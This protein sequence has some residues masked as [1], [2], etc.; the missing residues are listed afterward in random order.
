MVH[1]SITDRIPSS[2]A[3]ATFDTGQLV[4]T[5]TSGNVYRLGYNSATTSQNY[6]WSS[7]LAGKTVDTFIIQNST[8]FNFTGS[9]LINITN[10]IVTSS[11]TV[12]FDST[13]SF[14]ITNLKIKDSASVT[15]SNAV[16]TTF[17]N[18]EITSGTLRINS[19][20]ANQPAF[21]A[22]GGTTYVNTDQVSF[23]SMLVG[24]TGPATVT[25]N[26]FTG[27]WSSSS[28]S[29]SPAAGNGQLILNV[30]G[31][32]TVGSL[33]TIHM[34]GRGYAGGV[35][36]QNGYSYNGQGAGGAG[37]TYV[38]GGWDAP[39]SGGS[40]GTLGWYNHGSYV[41]STYGADDFWTQL[42]LG[43][44]GGAR[45]WADGGAGGGAIKITAS[46]L[47]NSGSILAVGNSG[48]D[49]GS[50]NG[51]SGG[52]VYVTTSG[53]VSNTG[54]ISVAGGYGGGSGR[55]RVD[56]DSLGTFSGAIYGMV[57]SSITDRIPSSFATAT[58]DTGQLVLTD[59]SG[60]VYRLGYNSSTT[61]LNY[62]WST[63]LAGK[64]IDTFIIQ[65]STGF[66]FT[67]ANLINI[68]NLIITSS[69]SVNFNTTASY[70]ITNLKIQNSASVTFTNA[71][72]MT[73]SNLEITFGTLRINS[74]FANHPIFVAQGGTTYVN[75]DQV[76]FGS[77]LVGT[78]APATVTSNGFTG[79]WGGS[80]YSSNPGAGNGQL[81]LNVDG[82][83]TV[84]SLGT[85]HMNGR[86]YAG[87]T[88]YQNGYSYNGQGQGGAGRAYGNGDWNA[89][90]SGGS[91]GTLGWYNHGSYVGST[92]G[93]NDF[94]TQLYLG[95]G[96][97]A[98]VW[99]DGGAGGGAVKITA[100]S[101]ANSGTI[102]AVGIGG[103][104]GGSP[105]GGSGG[106]IYI[107]TTGAVSNSGTLNV[108]GGYGGGAGRVRVDSDSLGTFS[109]AIYGMVHSSIAD[110]IP[111]S[112]G[113]AVFDT[114]QLVL[115]DTSG[116]VYRLGYN[117]S[118]TAHNYDWS[119]ALAGKTID[120]FIIQNS[121][122][123][124][125]TGSNLIN[126]T[127]LII[128]TSASVNFNTTASYNITNLKIQ[129]SASVTFTNAVNMTVSNLEMSSG[130]LTINSAFA[131]HPA[132][133]AQ[134]GTT[135]VNTDQVAFASM[136]VGT[137]G[138]ATIT[139]NGFTGTWNGSAYS[140]SPAA[141]NGQLILNI[142]GA[143]IIGS[144]GTVHMNG[145]GYVGGVDYQNGYSY[146]G[147]G[148]DGA[149]R[150]YGNGD[151]NAPFS[152]G[153]YGTS[154]WYNDG[155]YV[156][157][158]Y[159][160]SDFT[161][162]LYLGSG[163]GARVWA[164]GGAGGGAV[165]IT[166][167][168]LA[169]SG[170]ISAVG[171]SGEEGGS[172]NGGSGGTI[173]LSL[174]GDYVNTGSITTAGGNGGGQG[175]VAVLAD[176]VP[177]DLGSIV[178]VQDNSSNRTIASVNEAIIYGSSGTS[179]VNGTAIDCNGSAM[180]NQANPW[181]IPSGTTIT[182]LKITSGAWV[183][184]SN[185]VN[186][187]NI[188]V[189]SGGVLYVDN[190]NGLN[191][192]GN[193]IVA[194]GG[195][196]TGAA[197]SGTWSGSA[198][199]SNPASGNGQLLLSVGGDLS[200]Y[201]T[202]HMNAKGY[203]GGSGRDQEGYSLN[204]QGS[205]GAG[206]LPSWGDWGYGGGG[207]Y[208][209]V[210][211][212]AGSD[213][214][215]AVY[216][217][218]D[219]WTQLYL[220]SGGAGT[221]CQSGIA[222][223]GGAIKITATNL[224]NSGT[225]SSEGGTANNGCNGSYYNRGGS[226]GTLYFNVSGSF[227]NLGTLSTRGG[228]QGQPAVG[229]FGRVKID[230]GYIQGAPG[231]IYG[232]VHQSILATLGT[233][234]NSVVFDIANL[235]ITD[236]AYTYNLGNASSDSTINAGWVSGLASK[237]I[238][239][240]SVQNYASINL[241]GTQNLVVGTIYTNS[242]GI[243]SINSAFA[244]H[245]NLV[246]Q[247][248]TTYVNTDQVT[249][250]SIT[251]GTTGAATITT[252]GFSG[253]WS[254]SSY[255]TS[256]AAGNGQLILN[257][258]GDVNVGSYGTIHMNAK[259]YAGG[260]GQGQEGYSLNGQ[261]SDGAGRL[262][263]WGDWGYGGGGSYATVGGS[264]G[265]DRLG[266]VYGASN[267]WTEL[268][269]GSGGAGTQCQ[270]G[271]AYGGGAIKIT[272]T[273][274]INSGTVSSEG[275]TANNGC[276]GSYYN[277]GGSGG[278][279]Y[280]NVSG[281]FSNLGT[282]S[283]RGGAQGQP[284][285]GG[286][287]R[288]K[289]DANTLQLASGTIYGIL[290]N[291]M[292]D[293]LPAT[294]SA[295]TYDTNQLVIS[296]E[297]GTYRF[298][299]MSSTSS[300]NFDW[301]TFLNNHTVSSMTFINSIGFTFTSG[302]VAKVESITVNNGANVTFSDATQLTVQTIN[303]GTN[304]TVSIN[305]AFANHPNLVAQG[306]TTYVNTDQ[307]TFGSITLGTTGA[308]TITTSGFSGTWNGS[309]YSTT[310]AAGNGQ[311]ILNVDGDVNVGSYGTIHMN[312]KGY[313]GGSS[314]GQEGY[315]LNGQGTDGAGRYPS[316]TSNWSQATGGSYATVGAGGSDR[317]GTVYG[318]SD[319]WTQLYLGSGGAGTQCQSGIA[320][321]GGAIKITATNLINSGTVS[322]EGGTA[323]NGCN[324]SWYNRGG[325]GGTLY[326]N[327]SGSFSNLGTLSARGGAQGYGGVGGLGRV[328]IDTN[329]LQLATGTIYGILH[330]NIA[331]RLPATVSAITYDTNQLVI[332]S[333]GGTYQFGNMSST[334]SQNFDWR[335]FLNNHTVSSMTFIN[336]IGFTF[337]SGM[338]AKVE[339][340]TVNNGA[341]VTFSDATQLT[342]QTINVGTNGTVSINSAF[343]NHPN[344]VAQGG[345]TYVNTDQVT[346]GSITL[347]TTGA[348]TITTSGFSGTWNGSSYSTTPAA[349]NG[350]LILNVDGDV[351]VGS[352]GTIHMNAKG[353]AGGSSQ[354]QEGYSL[355][356]QGTDGAGRY[357]SD[358][359]NWSQATGGSYATV[360]AGGSDR[361][362]TVYGGSDFWTQLYLGSGGA[363]TQCQSGIAYGGGAIKITATNL[364]NSGTVSSEGG[365]A[366]NG[367][368]GSWY[369]RGGSGGTLY[370]NVSGSFSNLGTL[371][372]R[373]GAQGYGGVGGLG[374]I[375]VQ[376]GSGFENLGN[377]YPAITCDG[378][379][380][381]PDCL[382]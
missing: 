123:F 115:T 125:F 337:T 162:V 79:T 240:L 57:H 373:G 43:S 195:T 137:T 201:G 60:N 81:I 72:N 17:S 100:A 147:K 307:V 324:G 277:R 158:T 275:G 144:G 142:D 12:N 299:N 139:A 191:I 244:N 379:G 66:N 218:S 188:E 346:F 272:A 314:Q 154:G 271:I 318:G 381:E 246:A 130:N 61:S 321:G 113:T 215:G 348:A 266:A 177:S 24:T 93:A 366:N 190:P 372:A 303:V 69:A 350:Q 306:G 98:R 63:A 285:V 65:N 183:N 68:T 302:M 157:T 50:P 41:G 238:T 84:G 167:A 345:T 121:T 344:L 132:F 255:S 279:L 356:G 304:G 197:F 159:G 377:I 30:T 316:D 152:G 317:V 289:I 216:G 254:G 287:G 87:G 339:S 32:M 95:S 359:S 103:E 71:V 333:E 202:I 338:V 205:D 290:H 220:G 42:Y 208:A 361:V 223:G 210:G 186:I 209:T 112:F 59:T 294:V 368:N 217:A 104:E 278:T 194:S 150:A 354:G 1:S 347:G 118:T 221:Q 40:Y 349:G 143:M 342:V 239:S 21:V 281:S 129:S 382:N 109:G 83:V 286:F 269:L 264:L 309:S 211:G 163:G 78:T 326:F 25:S 327:V 148:A 3:T 149:G 323:N 15:I 224:I 336:S 219:F 200:N 91:Y 105:N 362:G 270:S 375:G 51:G 330:N 313:A 156:G 253:T 328:K 247:G 237:Q 107:N 334:S 293:R 76:V 233:Q 225:V 52:T 28:Y 58:F 222:Y 319:F 258:D 297:G 117:S 54:T 355:N 62:D 153:S 64:T 14:N 18:I 97:G 262:P 47:T 39:F 38:I 351:N 311:L 213:R 37:R 166:A 380:S 49:G 145:R 119:S 146:N 196:V 292:A 48:E 111:S 376:N 325:S 179:N 256:V 242:N 192:S 2:F 331:D 16:N 92:Y 127:N 214:L 169:N 55:V 138:P 227:S 226:G 181:T 172:P 343:A 284:A 160:A 234:L 46:S 370:F 198:Y 261:G 27:T 35:D 20:F 298:G 5:D 13:A 367:C 74:A 251:L 364:I 29:T 70:N 358:T 7:A 44:G 161:S 53:A 236:S 85:V 268:Y 151:W 267:F 260:S 230:A 360:G 80:S 363:G 365:T 10:L 165:K 340:I 67:G 120:T 23:A 232:I 204:G 235:T 77:M 102:S 124:N 170:T 265:S 249:F 33:G 6:D 4:L 369:N 305:S 22:Q 274:L 341:N 45:T 164:D 131:N 140:T 99:A 110:R 31:A 322:S 231:N 315:S 291:N 56:S 276:N 136:K 90:F 352:Y 288:V 199:S 263:S 135:Y 259:G 378:T 257:V 8:G 173:V 248:G 280:F 187:T 106:T 374:R 141:G 175:R 310:P 212:T 36:Y 308:A 207:S 108:A 19:A 75:T 73:V 88:D 94:W 122:G 189:Q 128:S 206:R 295:I 353:Y 116:N 282:L 180:C 184:I 296:A 243:V 203:A 134:G 82:A 300:Q 283:T 174:S 252:S 301:R 245:P 171:N 178:G 228:A 86:G 335:T 101:L 182:D 34:N 241:T 329:T 193:L 96:G 133:V 114:G 155:N 168:S 273:N 312:A 26:A 11:A 371:S 89:P 126:I 357:P 250:A 320:Y 229:G 332:S 185:D 9:N 176:G